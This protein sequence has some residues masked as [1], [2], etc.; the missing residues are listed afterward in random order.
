MPYAFI[1]ATPMRTLRVL[2]SLLLSFTI[3]NLLLAPLCSNGQGGGGI[4]YI[5]PSYGTN[6]A[7][8]MPMQ[9]YVGGV[10]SMLTV[11]WYKDGQKLPGETEAALTRPMAS[12]SDAGDYHAIIAADGA[13]TMT[14]V[15]RI[16]VSP[17]VIPYDQPGTVTITMND[18]GCVGRYVIGIPE[19]T[20]QWYFNRHL[21]R[22]QTGSSVCLSAWKIH[23]AGRYHMIASNRYGMVTTA[24]TRVRI[25]PPRPGFQVVGSVSETVAGA[26]AYLTLLPA[27][28]SFERGAQISW[29][30]NGIRLPNRTERVLILDNL[31]LAD[32]GSYRAWV[33]DIHGEH[34]STAFMLAVKLAAPRDIFFS[35]PG[36]PVPSGELFTVQAYYYGSPASAFRWTENGHR[37]ARNGPTLVAE[38]G[39][40]FRFF[41]L[42]IRNPYGHA[43]AQVGVAVRE[44]TVLDRW[45]WRSPA[46]QGSRMRA[47]AWGNG[48]YV[49][50]GTAGNVIVSEN[51][52]SWTNVVLPT[53]ENFEAIAF[54]KGRFVASAGPLVLVSRD[55]L[56]WDPGQMPNADAFHSL[57]YG[58]GKFLAGG[59]Y[60]NIYVSADGYAWSARQFAGWRPSVS[61]GNGR[62]VAAGNDG[63]SPV[64]FYS[65]DGSRWHVAELRNAAAETNGY[66]Y[67]VGIT[68]TP[69]G[70]AAVRSQGGVYTS[71]DG[72]EWFL[73]RGQSGDRFAQGIAGRAGQI[74]TTDPVNAGTVEVSGDGR[75]WTRVATGAHQELDA[76]CFANGQYVAVGGGGT[77]VTSPDGVNWTP[78]VD[79]L[80]DFYGAARSSNLFVVAGDGGTIMTS[81]DGQSWT[82]QNTP[83]TRNLHGLHFADG[84]Y[85]AVGR[86]GI[87][88]TST[89]GATWTEVRSGVG[90]YLERVTYGGGMWLAVGESNSVS[91]SSDG[92]QWTGFRLGGTNTSHEGVAYGKGTWVVAGG[93][94][95]GP[96]E[97]NGKPTIS[98][99]TNLL[100]WSAASISDYSRD[101]RIRDIAFGN[102]TFVAV[103]NSGNVTVS[104]DAR[105][106]TTYR[107][108]DENFRRVIFN[109]E[110]FIAVGNNGRCYSTVDPFSVDAWVRHSVSTGQNLHDIVQT[111]GGGYLTVGN[112]SMILQS[113]EEAPASK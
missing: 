42:A 7:G 79:N 59:N 47:I 78:R 3:G 68:H 92:V 13:V 83:T 71:R 17:V 73:S 55:G 38:A 77:I 57:T 4:P 36:R 91:I 16:F 12:L 39:H 34:Q 40:N 18:S 22:G 99:S 23:H 113:G 58:E 60:G 24:V 10:F 37:V 5:V 74:I 46:P 63:V 45:Q 2:C 30:H 15:I 88:I 96:L 1:S 70:F 111:P 6:I 85:V 44:S 62:F 56:Q 75:N 28:G 14:G 29:M 86:K 9:L 89:D 94:F 49:A 51:G 67:F 80:I 25:R 50:V 87:M 8:G 90:D 31:S 103:G 105:S 108:E 32:S 48:R 33:K 98:I 69:D 104:A 100:T 106:W 66:S 76:I 20:F 41:D 21:M 112:N 53:T 84:R 11:Q 110:R 81:N 97:S 61:A 93:Y 52:L 54:G 82:R 102:G 101:T 107:I 26:S 64:F 19:T 109:G 72:I 35:K 27:A 43:N 65:A 95:T